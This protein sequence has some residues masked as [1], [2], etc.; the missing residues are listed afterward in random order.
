MYYNNNMYN[1]YNMQI[2]FFL[3][4]RSFMYT[5]DNIIYT[6]RNLVTIIL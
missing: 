5:E 4:E 2:L 6:V 3:F 1:T